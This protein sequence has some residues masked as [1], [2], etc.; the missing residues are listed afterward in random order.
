MSFCALQANLPL[1]LYNHTM[2]PA[3]LIYNPAAG[4]VSVRPYVYRAVKVLRA[5]GWSVRIVA[6]KSGIH[7]TEL[8]CQAAADRLAA[9]FAVG[10]DGTLGQV[11]AGLMHSSTALGILPAGT[12]NVLALE[13]GLTPFEWYRPWALE[14]NAAELA[15]G[16]ILPMDL[17]LCNGQP[18]LLWSGLGL[19]ARVIDWL[20]PR[21]RWLKYVSVPH[22]F[23][24][25]VLQAA[26]WKGVDVTIRG[27]GVEW[28]G[29]VVQGVA[30]NIR[31]YLGGMAELTPDAYLDDGL[32]ELWLLSG[33]TWYENMRHGFGLMGGRHLRAADAHCIRA[34]RL[35]IE[36]SRPLPAQ[37][38]G[39]PDGAS[40]RMVL[41]NLPGALRMIVPVGARKLFKNG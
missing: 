8:A 25:T 7:A 11:A 18:F 36:A 6:T 1:S 24:A 13:M 21:P 23:I 12:T 33:S 5:A 41:E 19:D 37:L 32:L 14:Q 10:G 9:V 27:E 35:E 17:G 30:S 40:N 34:R 20:E 31:R 38:D 22:Y 16:Q 2:Q 28:R 3:L 26:V 4:R 39:D 29:H 15:R